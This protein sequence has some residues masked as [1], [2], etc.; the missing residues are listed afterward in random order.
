LIG[1]S[2][3]YASIRYLT[4]AACSTCRNQKY[5]PTSPAGYATDGPIHPYWLSKAY[6]SGLGKILLH[7]KFTSTI[8]AAAAAELAAE[9]A[10]RACR[11]A[12]HML[13]VKEN[14]CYIG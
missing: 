13:D 7:P 1:S 8:G 6:R 3:E 2:G 9:T 11:G 10:D 14:I 12:R 4:S 5:R